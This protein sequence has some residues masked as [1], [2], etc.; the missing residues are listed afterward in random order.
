MKVLKGLIELVFPAKCPFCKEIMAGQAEGIC[1]SCRRKVEFIQ[2]PRC[3]KCGKPIFNKEKEFCYDCVQNNYYF[4]EG[5]NLWIHKPPVSDAIYEFKYQNRKYYGYIFG[6]EMGMR[7]LDYVERRKIDLIVPV[8]LHKRRKRSRGYNQA[9]ILGRKISEITG[10]P[11]VVD[12]LIRLKKTNPQ[13]ILGHRDRRANIKGAFVTR[14]SF[15][16]KNILLIDDI[17][18]TGN[19]LS[20][21]A[22]VLKAAGASKVYF[23]TISIGQGF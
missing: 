8:P 18:T 12:S 4:E 21:A 6:K 17:Y 13:K 3:K 23:L 10:I 2:E 9:E 14:K 16:G 1:A 20:E 5:R 15:Q 11:M 19:T 22:R 7:Y